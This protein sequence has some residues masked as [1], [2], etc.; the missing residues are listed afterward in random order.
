SSYNNLQAL[1]PYRE[2]VK[3]KVINVYSR[4]YILPAQLLRQRT[5]RLSI[6]DTY[7]YK[8]SRNRYTT[9]Y[10]YP[11]KSRF[12]YIK[13][14]ALANKLHPIRLAAKMHTYPSSCLILQRLSTTCPVTF[15]TKMPLLAR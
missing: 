4:T 8:D 15:H 13:R 1:A 7:Y 2:S 5:N 12:A 10:Y 9:N 3:D 6:L 11:I 14:N